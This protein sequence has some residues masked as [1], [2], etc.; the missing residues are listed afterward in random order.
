MVFK[1]LICKSLVNKMITYL[2]DVE[3]EKMNYTKKLISIN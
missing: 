2:F 1:Y 3:I